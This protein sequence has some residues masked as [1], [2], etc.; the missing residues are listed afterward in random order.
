MDIFHSWLKGSRPYLQSVLIRE[1]KNTNLNHKAKFTLDWL[2]WDNIRYAAVQLH[3][4]L[5]D[6]VVTGVLSLAVSNKLLPRLEK[7]C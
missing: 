2:Q 1:G 4:L 7:V 6:L 3:G 5:A